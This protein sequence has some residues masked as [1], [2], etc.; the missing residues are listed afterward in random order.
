MRP[1]GGGASAS[2]TGLAGPGFSVLGVLMAPVS[3]QHRGAL[4]LGQ[5]RRQGGQ[6]GG[7]AREGAAPA[8][9]GGALQPEPCAAPPARARCSA[10]AAWPHQQPVAGVA[11]EVLLPSDGAV[12]LT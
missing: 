7:G 3:L 11:L 4:C 12:I 2:G 1:R 10:H 8:G 6:V 5:S 9:F